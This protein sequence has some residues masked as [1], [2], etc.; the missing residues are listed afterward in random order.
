MRAL[1]HH[2]T[3]DPIG[4]HMKQES[5]SDNAEGPSQKEQQRV[6]AHG[7]VGMQ[8]VKVDATAVGLK[9]GVRKQMIQIHQ[10]RRKED[11]IGLFPFCPKE[12]I[13]N[14]EGKPKVQEIVD[15]G[16]HGGHLIV[17][18]FLAIARSLQEPV[19]LQVIKDDLVYM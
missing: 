3:I 14:E 8:W 7:I 4:Q 6:S 16:L 18:M 5:D 19:R 1:R 12:T 2:L 10:H 11:Q 17:S 13:C 15:K 9:N